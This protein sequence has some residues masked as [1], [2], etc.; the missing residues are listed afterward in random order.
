M[1]RRIIAVGLFLVA[2]VVAFQG[3]WNEYRTL[4]SL[5]KVDDHPLYVMR[6][7]GDYGFEKPV[8][9]ALPQSS[10]ETS[11]VWVCTCFASLNK[12]GDLIF[13]RNF[14]WHVHPALL[15][16]TDP[17]DGYASVSMVDISYLGY[18]GR[19]PSWLERGNLLD[20]PQIPFDG[21]NER[22]LVVGMMAVPHAEGGSD[23]RK[24]TVDSLLAI[25]LMLDYAAN[26]DE[27]AALLQRHNVDFGGGPPLHYLVADSSGNS[28]V[29]ELLDGEVRIIRNSAPWQVATNFVIADVAPEEAN[30]PC[31]RYNKAYETLEQAGG[32]VSSKEAMALLED[33]SQ[34]G[35]YPTIWSVVHNGTTGEVRVVMG[36]KYGEVH[37]FNLEMKG[38]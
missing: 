8:Q 14:D 6:Y 18:G 13:G 28:A 3:H 16:F 38:K 12:D 29:L 27:A 20:A 19:E 2:L 37:T 11:P 36:R 34:S 1:K 21:M 17:P 31:W 32:G 25:R 4:A 15:L 24:P 5:K 35:D 9:D 30:S 7:Y 26:V 22:G 10:S 23:P 33:V